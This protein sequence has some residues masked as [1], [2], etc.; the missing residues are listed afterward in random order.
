MPSFLSPNMRLRL[1]TENRA[2]EIYTFALRLQPGQWK[3]SYR[4]QGRRRGT[5]WP[6][7]V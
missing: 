3:P 7:A 1:A 6:T 4:L 2:A 5:D